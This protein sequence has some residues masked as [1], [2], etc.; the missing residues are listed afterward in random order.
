[1]ENHSLL[2]TGA[3][4]TEEVTPDLLSMRTLIANVLMVGQP[5]Q[6]SWVLVDTGMAKFADA[7]ADTAVQRFGRPPA[8]IVLTHGHFDHVGTVKELADRWNVPVYA[9]GLELPYL[10]GK[11]NYPPADPTVGG[12]LMARAALA[13]PNEGINLGTRVHALPKDGSLPE[14]PEWRWIHTPGHSPGH[15]SLYRERDGALIAGDAF[16]TV[17]QESALAVVTQSKELHGPPMYFTPDWEAAEQSVQKLAALKPQVAITGHGVSM[18]G[19]ELQESL[20]RLAEHFKEMAVPKQGKYV[21]D[22]P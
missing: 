9:H 8:C 1:M 18:A 4:D 19:A 17:K 6:G 13:Y 16:I 12:G 5:Q 3:V 21:E 2:R 15:I 20:L 14:L 7:I 10:T 22:R 11:A